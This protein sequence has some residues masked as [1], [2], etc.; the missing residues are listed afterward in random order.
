MEGGKH[1]TSKS[2][3]WNKLLFRQFRNDEIRLN[4]KVRNIKKYIFKK[5]VPKSSFGHGS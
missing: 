3:Y 2:L 5:L 1:F 4:N